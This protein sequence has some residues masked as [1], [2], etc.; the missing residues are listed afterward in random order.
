MYTIFYLLKGDYADC[1]LREGTLHLQETGTLREAKVAVLE[2]KT[3]RA[4]I[5]R[6][7]PGLPKKLPH[8]TSHPEPQTLVL[9]QVVVRKHALKLASIGGHNKTESKY[10][11]RCVPKRL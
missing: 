10:I 5:L 9:V 8:H 3:P 1:I 11:D 4:G 7:G 6:P 2:Q